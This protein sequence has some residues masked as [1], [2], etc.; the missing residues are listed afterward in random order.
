[1]LTPAGDRLAGNRVMGAVGSRGMVCKELQRVVKI[2]GLLRLA[3]ILMA[4]GGALTL[5]R[6][7]MAAETQP[8]YYAHPIVEDA[9]GVVAPWYNGQNGQIDYRI[10]RAAEVLL[11]SGWS[12]RDV[13]GTTVTGSEILLGE[14]RP[15]PRDGPTRGTRP[16]RVR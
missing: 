13:A 9:L 10:G 3:L 6:T 8:S 1:M 11:N 4:V 15:R 14:R 7:V 2:L 12:V 5:T 16:V